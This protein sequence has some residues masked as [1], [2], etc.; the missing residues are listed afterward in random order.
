MVISGIIRPPPEI[1][2]VADRTAQYVAKN[3]RAFEVR[4]LKSDRGKTPKFAFL[5]ATSPFHAYY[6]DRIVY[7]QQHDTGSDDDVAAAAA[8]EDGDKKKSKKDSQTVAKHNPVSSSTT[9]SARK[10]EKKQKASAID[11]IAKALL[12]QRTKIL[13]AKTLQQEGDDDEN[14]N[15]KEQQTEDSNANVAIS[16]PP[17]SALEMAAIGAPYNLSAAQIETIQLVAQLTAMDGKGG[18]FLHQLT[19]R[20]WNNP[21][22]QFCQPR[23]LHFAYFSALVDAYRTILREWISNSSSSTTTTTTTTN[24]ISKMTTA[25]TSTPESVL[26][27]A[28]YRAEYE[29]YQQLEQSQQQQQLQ[30]EGEIVAIDWHNFVV[31]ET[32]DFPADEMVINMLPLPSVTEVLS[33]P[34]TTTTAAGTTTT[35]AAL[36]PSKDNAMEESSDEEEEEGENIRVVPSYQ[37]KVVGASDLSSTRAID[38]ITG[39]SI[40]VADVPEH[41]R[42]QLLDPRWAEER[43]KF[44]EKQKDSNLV[45]GDAM[46]ANISRLAREREGSVTDTTTTVTS[47]TN[48][49]VPMISPVS[50]TVPKRTFEAVGAATVGSNVGTASLPMDHLISKKPRLESMFFQSRD[51]SA[52]P[53]SKVDV[54]LEEDPVI[55]PV[56]EKTLVSEEDFMASLDSPNVTLRIKIPNDSTQ[57]AWNF[58]GQLVSIE[59]NVMTKVKDVKTQLSQAHLNDMPANKVVLKDPKG[60]FLSNN[61]TLASL[62]I[63]PTATLEMSLK[64]RGGRK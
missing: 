62:N 40:S 11:P 1:R 31:V 30:E 34:T 23:H 41:L 56:E 33:T 48:K 26:R 43:K 17:P 13:K 10:K 59:T 55:V 54:V 32:I 16:L 44:Q 42:I 19:L 64:Q 3:G 57:M 49:A 12:D 51:T 14:S 50:H 5:Q 58:Y 36:L 4:I 20:E 53:T 63:G 22:F 45:S 6:E 60:G 35:V 18:P 28:A 21:E 29:R 15:N 52:D 39:K 9:V 46:V 61:V 24:E 38:P 27:E 25:V 2:V 37:P 8:K 7:Y 47:T